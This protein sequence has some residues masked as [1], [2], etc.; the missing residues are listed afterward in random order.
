MAKKTRKIV[1]KEPKISNKPSVAIRQAVA[2]LE[3]IEKMPEFMIDM[4]MYFGKLE[5]ENG[6]PKGKCAVCFAGAMIARAKNDPN[7]Y[8]EPDRFPNKTRDKLYGLDRFRA[9]YISDGLEMFGIK[10]LPSLLA[11]DVEVPEYYDNKSR[12]KKKMLE[13]SDQLK[14]FG[15]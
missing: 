13:I 10:K 12:F 8:I 1:L 4:N 7:I 6:N 9:G 11:H 15:L 5:D 2:D 3:A 14:A